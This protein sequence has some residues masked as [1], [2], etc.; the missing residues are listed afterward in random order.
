MYFHPWCWPP[1]AVEMETEMC[2]GVFFSQM[3]SQGADWSV[4]VALAGKAR[5]H[6][7]RLALAMAQQKAFCAAAHSIPSTPQ[8]TYS[9][10]R[11]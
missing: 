10:L 3:L 2:L 1:K 8:R 5:F 4:H 11:T 7:W 9:V 6:F